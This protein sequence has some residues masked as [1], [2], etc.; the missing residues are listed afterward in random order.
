MAVRWRALLFLL[1]LALVLPA[2]GRGK[3]SGQAPKTTATAASPAPGQPKIELGPAAYTYERENRNQ[4]VMTDVTFSNPTDKPL[5]VRW[6][7]LQA[8]ADEK[9]AGPT[10]HRSDLRRELD[11]GD[12]VSSAV[13]F[14]RLDP[15]KP[16]PVEL[17]VTYRDQDDKLGFTRKLPVRTIGTSGFTFRLSLP[18]TAVLV[19]NQPPR[20]GQ[21]WE[22]RVF[23][24]IRNATKEPLMF[25]PFWFEAISDEQ[26]VPHSGDEP[27]LLN[28]VQKIDPGTSLKGALLWRFRGTGPQ[29]K[30]IRVAFPAGEKPEFSE[31]IEVTA[32]ER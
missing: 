12:S 2:C 14:Y 26:R 25:V 8:A 22:V 21:S 16:K 1:P 10:W 11:P 29:P 24:E 23:C 30:K 31:T 28:R 19:A 9:L 32:P 20:H 6:E 17:T 7:G 15:S 3:K 13:S 4:W 27:V 5:A 18:A